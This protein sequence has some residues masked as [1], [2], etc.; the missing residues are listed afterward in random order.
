M[1]TYYWSQSCLIFQNEYRNRIKRETYYNLSI[2]T[3]YEGEPFI[4]FSIV[5]KVTPQIPLLN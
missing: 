1:Y 4:L 5:D 2:E 3:E